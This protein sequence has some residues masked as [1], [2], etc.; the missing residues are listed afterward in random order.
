[1]KSKKLLIKGTAKES[2]VTLKSLHGKRLSIFAIIKSRFSVKKQCILFKTIRWR[3]V[4]GK[5]WRSV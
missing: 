5:L 2:V 4:T 1:M 3:L